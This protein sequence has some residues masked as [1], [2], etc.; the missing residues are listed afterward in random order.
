MSASS[1]EDVVESVTPLAKP[2]HVALYIKPLAGQFGR[3][4]DTNGLE[5]R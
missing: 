4:H 1:S 5:R 3:Q 2:D